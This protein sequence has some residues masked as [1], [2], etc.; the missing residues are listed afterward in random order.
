MTLPSRSACGG[1]SAI[2]STQRTPAIGTS[3][4]AK[5]LPA[6][7]RRA[8]RELVDVLGGIALRLERD[9]TAEHEPADASVAE[10]GERDDHPSSI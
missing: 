2:A 6:E 10:R 8:L 4:E 5:S 3:A 1:G 9:V 7:T